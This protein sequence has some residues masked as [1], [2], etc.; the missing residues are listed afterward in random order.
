MNFTLQ[1]IM[2]LQLAKDIVNE[3]EYAFYLEAAA[4]GHALDFRYIK[5][6]KGFEF[7]FIVK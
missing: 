1:T 7:E 2:T 6:E 4:K 3:I 5:K